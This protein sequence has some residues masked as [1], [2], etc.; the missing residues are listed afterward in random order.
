MPSARQFETQHVSTVPP[1]YHVR[2]VKAGTHEIRVAFPPGSRKKGSGKVVEVLHPRGENPGCA[3]RSNPLELVVMGA[4]PMR[5]GNPLDSFTRDEKLAL[6]RLGIKWKSIRTEADANRARRALKE[7]GEVKQRYNP[8]ATEE[9]PA[10]IQMPESV[11]VGGEPDALAKEIY[12]GFHDADANRAVVT[13]EPHIPRGSYAQI[14]V[15]Y[16]LHVKPAE[17]APDRS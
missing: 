1:G 16:A 14:G 12:A 11:A 6:G 2:T 8:I 4:N 10:D 13:N 3:A 7:I 5:R 9:A 15:L 17:G